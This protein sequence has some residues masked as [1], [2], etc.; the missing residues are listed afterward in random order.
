MS[1]SVCATRTPL[2]S[3]R[4]YLALAPCGDGDRGIQGSVAACGTLVLVPS[5]LVCNPVRGGRDDDGVEMN[6]RDE[7]CSEVKC[8]L[9]DVLAGSED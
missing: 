9:L 4:K 1:S 7:N 2:S 5:R 3:C 8:E 6:V